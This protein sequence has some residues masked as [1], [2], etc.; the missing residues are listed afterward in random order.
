[1]K[2][3]SKHKKHQVAT[4]P[5]SESERIKNIMRTVSNHGEPTKLK[6]DTT[7]RKLHIPKDTEE[8]KCHIDK[9]DSYII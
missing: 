9:K 2:K 3:K 6:F 1:M 7:P 4:H 5:I 8:A